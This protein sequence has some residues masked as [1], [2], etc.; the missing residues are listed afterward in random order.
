MLFCLPLQSICC[1]PM[2][3]VAEAKPVGSVKMG[4]IDGFIFALKCWKR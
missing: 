2:P 4:N 3:V 1:P